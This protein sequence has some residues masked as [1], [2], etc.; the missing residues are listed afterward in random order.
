[1]PYKNIEKRKEYHRD[2][3]GEYNKIHP[4]T[5]EQKKKKADYMRIWSAK[6]KDRVKVLSH[7]SYLKNKAKRLVSQ[8]KYREDNSELV[9]IRHHK[10]YL[11]K[12]EYFLKKS[13]EYSLKNKDKIRD[14]KRLYGRT[15][16]NRF[17]A[18]KKSAKAR[19]YGFDLSKEDFVKLFNGNCHY[20]N[21][22]N[23][24]GIDRKHNNVGYNLEN[25]L[26]CCKVCNYMKKD[27]SYKD[28]IENIKAIYRVLA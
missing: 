17:N 21:K 23:C 28:F 18:Y 27:T 24:R 9:K 19:G 3:M 11:S 22:E 8:K 6:N 14:Y 2:Y 10:Y 1:M 16:N 20:C 4:I 26:S 13:Q 5:P 7:K 12:R 15:S 25:S